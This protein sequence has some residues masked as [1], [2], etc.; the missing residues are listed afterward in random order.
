MEKRCKKCD[1]VSAASVDH[2]IMFYRHPTAKDGFQ[3][4]CKKCCLQKERD[5]RTK[6][7]EKF[8]I[9]DRVQYAKHK[10]SNKENKKRWVKN[11]YAKVLLGAAKQRAKAKNIP[12]DIKADDIT[13][14]TH[15]PVLGIRLRQNEDGSKRPFDS[16]SLDRII[17]SLGYVRT[18]IRVISL[19][20]NRIKHDATVEELEAVLLY[21]KQAVTTASQGD[22][23]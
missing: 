11:N 20:A 3:S 6:N 7:P 8:K 21:V 17:P 10:D 16:P 15:C 9:K 5:Y 23:T 4:S 2:S 18:N 1:A 19:R 22:H 13:I 14:P 12:F